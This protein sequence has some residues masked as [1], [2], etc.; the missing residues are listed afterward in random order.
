[1]G[2]H[3]EQNRFH[4]TP[5]CPGSAQ[6]DGDAS[7]QQSV[8]RLRSGMSPEQTLS[9]ILGS[10]EYYLRIC[11]ADERYWV[12]RAF[13]DLAGR[14][15]TPREYQRWLGELYATN[16]NYVA[17]DLVVRF[18]QSVRGGGPYEPDYDYARPFDYYRR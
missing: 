15:P 10:P 13:T 14:P 7:A 4:G 3:M 2:S 11:H 9:L 1:M 18:P 16:R 6:P 12:R 8:D 17:Y 5:G